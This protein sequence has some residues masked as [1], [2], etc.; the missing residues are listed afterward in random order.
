MFKI[1]TKTGDKG[2][3]QLSSG[4]R[5]SKDETQV[6]AIGTIDELNAHIGLL[7]TYIEEKTLLER[8]HNLQT[9][10]FDIGGNKVIDHS[11]TTQ[12]EKDMDAMTESLPPLRDFVYPGGC[13]AAAQSHVCRT[14]CRRAERNFV[15][16]SK[17]RPIDASVLCFLNRLSDYFF[18]LARKLNFIYNVAEKTW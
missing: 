15:T 7:M 12:L 4:E 11:L 8:L 17:I 10:L 9:V 18:I 14:V 1:Y 3:T 5:V 2:T 16:L 6:E 13:K